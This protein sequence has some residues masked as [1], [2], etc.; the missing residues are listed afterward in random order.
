MR[1]PRVPDQPHRRF[2]ADS[3]RSVADSHERAAV[4][5]G[6][7]RSLQ[8]RRAQRRAVAILKENGIEA[9]NLKGGIVAWIDKVDPTREVLERAPPEL[10]LNR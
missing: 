8:D 5:S 6:N 1:E 2:D 10:D 7:H 9:K 4:R 3:A